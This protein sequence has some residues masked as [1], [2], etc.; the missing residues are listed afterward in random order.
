MSN[1][2]EEPIIVN[3]ITE[4]K[5]PKTPL[6]NIVRK[7]ALLYG[8]QITETTGLDFILPNSKQNIPVHCMEGISRSST[9]VIDYLSHHFKISNVRSLIQLVQSKRSVINPNYYFKEVLET[10]HR[11]NTPVKD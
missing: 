8:I 1:Q 9:V 10:A 6:S 7:T 3:N 11:K 2:E 4:E 5:K